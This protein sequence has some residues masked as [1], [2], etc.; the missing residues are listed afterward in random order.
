MS[1][2]PRHR[3]R[4]RGITSL[5]GRLTPRGVRLGPRGRCA[6]PKRLRGQAPG[7]VRTNRAPARAAHAWGFQGWKAGPSARPSAPAPS[8]TRPVLSIRPPGMRI[9]PGLPADPVAGLR[10]ARRVDQAGNVSCVAQHERTGPGQ[11]LGC[12]ETTCPRRQV[13]VHR[14]GNESRHFDQRQVD[15]RPEHREATRVD[16][17]VVAEH[18]E[19]LLVQTSRQVGAVRIPRQDVEDGRVSPINHWLTP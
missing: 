7:P 16:K 11:Q 4:G 13:V 18:L 2:G 17:Q 19:E 3:R 12:P 1:C 8:W 5:A 10:V 14:A 9:S 6:S 15:G